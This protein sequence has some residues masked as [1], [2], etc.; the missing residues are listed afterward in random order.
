M[1]IG[2]ASSDGSDGDAEDSLLTHLE[3]WFLLEGDRR[4]VALVALGL[5]SVFVVGPF[6]VGA[7]P[8]LNVQSLFYVFSALLGGNVT[9]ITVVV[10]INQLLLSHEL[11][12]PGELRSQIDE[13]IEYRRNVE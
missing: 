11:K 12:D 9:L 3:E 13:V 8:L 1:D 4:T 10:S 7:V 5:L 6:A 2:S